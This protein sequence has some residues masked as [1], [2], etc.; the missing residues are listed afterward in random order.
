[1]TADHEAAIRSATEQLV[2]AF[3]AAV[4]AEATSR[5]DAPER[6]FSIPEAA[7]A[8]SLARSSIYKEMGAGRLR[9]IKCGRRRFIPSGALRD[10]IG[11][12]AGR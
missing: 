5:E 3:V 4:R 10:Y 7:D 8:L 9:S 1:V 6:L 2:A 12:A 11:Q